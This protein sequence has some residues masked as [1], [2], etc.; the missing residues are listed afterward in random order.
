MAIGQLID[1][2]AA[3]SHGRDYQALAR[4]RLITARSRSGL[5]PSAF[6]ACL[7]ERLGWPV[8][9]DAVA[10]W[11]RAGSPPSD[12]LLAAE[13]VAGSTLGEPE[14]EPLRLIHGVTALQAALAEVVDTAHDTLAITGSRS[15]EPDYLTRIEHAVAS[16]PTL[17]Y[18][19]VLYGPP[20][21]GATKNHLLRLVDLQVAADRL[22]LGMVTDLGRDME[23]FICANETMAVVIVPSLRGIMDFDTAFAVADPDVASRWVAHV[24][25][26]YLGA[27]PL[28]TRAQIEAL[29]VTR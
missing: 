14:I 17:T 22:Q 11:E 28:A 1:L 15:R 27:E 2:D 26:A 23:R 20:R 29:E 25:M 12:V 13:A 5:A 19:R 3:R 24:H 18:W 8:T 21:H 7:G 4:N 6:A 16:R 10:A 9:G